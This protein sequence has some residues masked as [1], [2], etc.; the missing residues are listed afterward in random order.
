MKRPRNER[1]FSLIEILVAMLI[2]LV[3][4]GGIL[5]LLGTGLTLHRDGLTLAVGVREADEIARR[6]EEAV[7]SGEPWDAETRS[8]SRL[9][10]TRLSSGTWYDASFE[11][12]IGNEREGSL[13]AWV[14][15][16][17][18]VR[19]LETARPVPIVVSPLTSLAHGAR[20]FR[21]ASESR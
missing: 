19:A 4:I 5:A 2:F 8:W 11:P 15:V 16:A 21:Q 3:G 18:S 13:L 7:E 20:R 1:G 12:E 14:R 10:A 9:E 6:I 17:G